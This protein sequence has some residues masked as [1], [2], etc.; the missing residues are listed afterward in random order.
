MTSVTC[1]CYEINKF[2]YLLEQY[3]TIWGGGEI[4]WNIIEETAACILVD[5]IQNCVLVRAFF[6]NVALRHECVLGEWRYSSTHS[7]T[8]ALDV[9]EWSVS[10]PGRFPPKE[11]VPGTHW[12][13]GWVGPRA[14]L[15]AVM[16]RK[17]PRTHRESN[18]RTSI[19]QSWLFSDC[20]PL[21]WIG[22]ASVLIC[23]EM[24]F[25]IL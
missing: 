22:S 24:G 6:L 14:I 16:K 8:S 1:D 25:E 5:V 18:P 15:D 4:L 9:G 11:K 12:I 17:I 21:R 20:I 13:G 3:N 7:L 19:A 10:R 2:C 23:A